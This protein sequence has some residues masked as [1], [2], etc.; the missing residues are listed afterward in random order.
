MKITN[1]HLYFLRQQQFLVYIIK[2]DLKYKKK[3]PGRG[4][5]LRTRPY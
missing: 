4:E 1:I 2:A 5:I 3:I